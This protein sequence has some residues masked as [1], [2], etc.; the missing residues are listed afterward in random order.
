QN[1]EEDGSNRGG[2]QEV[3]L[4]F[5]EILREKKGQWPSSVPLQEIMTE[6]F[7]FSRAVLMLRMR[8]RISLISPWHWKIIICLFVWSEPIKKSN[9]I[10]KLEQSCIPIRPKDLMS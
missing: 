10:W 4:R 3:K 5:S 8:R 9:S 6:L 1:E 7:L 2:S